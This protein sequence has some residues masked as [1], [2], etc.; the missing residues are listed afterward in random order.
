M[1][2]KQLSQRIAFLRRVSLFSEL[3]DKELAACIDSLSLR[4]YARS[5]I[6]FHQGD[7]SRDLYV[8]YEGKVRIFKTDPAG[9]ET[10][11]SLFG[12]RDVVGEFAVIDGGPRSATARTVGPCALLCMAG[13]TF[14]H[15]MRAMPG[16]ALGMTR[17][18]VSKV[19]WTATYAEAMAQLDAAGRLLY[20]LLSYNERFGQELEAGK[21]YRLDLALTQNDLASLI[22]V[23]REWVN[24]CLGGWRN[25]GLLEYE[26][27]TITILDL[28]ALTSERDS[29]MDLHSTEMDW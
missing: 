25:R 9:H 4:R 17:L 16:L 14:L 13:D 24:R 12:P 23:R 3:S 5:E 15:Y 19:R 8:V 22:G 7:S 6:I 27:G 26:S 28:P 18:L 29:R 10:S 20:L 1:I 2:P 11:I 21:R